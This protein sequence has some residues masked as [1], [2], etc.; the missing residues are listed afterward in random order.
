[1]LDSGRHKLSMLVAPLRFSASGSLQQPISFD[2]ENFPAGTALDGT[3][4]FDSYRVTYLYALRQSS[5]LE[6]DIGFTGKIRDAE[7]SLSGG[8]L[9]AS[10]ANTGFVP[11][12]SFSVGWSA[13]KDL[14][15]LIEGD[16]L[17]SPGGQGRAED[18]FIGFDYHTGSRLG[19]RAGYR[20]LEGGADVE[21]VYNFT[22]IHYLALGVRLS[23]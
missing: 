19:L 17:A 22:F 4:R 1:V 11:L 7:V 18:V 21:E 8:G 20:F 6:I 10:Y 15:F 23:F 9:K 5:K 13:R 16:A 3:Y 14:R 2:G 12:F